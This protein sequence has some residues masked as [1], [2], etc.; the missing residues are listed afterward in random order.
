MKRDRQLVALVVLLWL[1]ST[2]AH[3]QGPLSALRQNDVGLIFNT[4]SILFDL[5][6]YQGGVGV[7]LSGDKMAYRLLF[8]FF[9]STES[10]ALD[11]SLGAAV[12]RRLATGRVTPY[13]GGSLTLGYGKADD[14]EVKTVSV[15][16]TVGG[17][18]GVEVYL[19][20]FLS[21]FAEYDLSVTMKYDRTE[22]S[23]GG[24]ESSD[25]TVDWSVQLGPGNQS[26]IG[27]VFYFL[28][29]RDLQLEPVANGRR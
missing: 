29:G 2:T 8:D 14:G 20:R 19:L 11:V 16:V 7:E 18:F 24:L 22:S 26:K 10:D 13:A 12:E 1:S 15:P 21:I 3:A 27:V 9:Y 28:R 17:L 5:E 6:S 25:T 4:D 23:V